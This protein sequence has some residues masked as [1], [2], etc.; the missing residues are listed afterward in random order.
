[1]E[2]VTLEI[3]ENRF[4]KDFISEQDQMF[5]EMV[6]GFV[7]EV[8][9]PIRREIEQSKRSDFKLIEDLQRKLIPLGFLS[10][11]CPRSMGAWA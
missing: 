7:D 8:I 4:I 9:M 10:G 6:R 1:M 5:I 11:S 3:K 2:G